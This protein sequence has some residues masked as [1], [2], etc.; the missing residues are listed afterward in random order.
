RS[1][2]LMF[3]ATVLLRNVPGQGGTKAEVTR[4]L[5]R[6]LA[7]MPEEIKRHPQGRSELLGAWAD[8]ARNFNPNAK[9]RNIGM[10]LSDGV[11]ESAYARCEKRACTF[12]KPSFNLAGPEIHLLGIGSGLPADRAASLARTWE[13]WFAAAGVNVQTFRCVRVF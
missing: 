8:A 7:T 9:G 3:R 6:F 11:E 2:P 10:M 1:I 12:P 13:S 4:A 5:L